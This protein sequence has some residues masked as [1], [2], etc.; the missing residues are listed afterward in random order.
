[1]EK[2][3]QAYILG[4]GHM[5]HLHQQHL[6]ALGISCTTYDGEEDCYRRIL[7]FFPEENEVIFVASPAQSHRSYAFLALAYGFD[8]FVE[9][10]IALSM[11]EVNDLLKIAKQSHALLFAG[12]CERYSLAFQNF[13]KK[14]QETAAKIAP[15]KIE[16]THWNKPT[17]RGQDVSVIWDLGVHDFDLLYTMKQA[18]PSWDSEK[19]EIYFDESREAEESKREIKATFQVD[20]VDFVLTCNLNETQPM[21]SDAIT[22]EIQE[23]LRIRA[24]PD[25]ERFEAMNSQLAGAIFAVQEA[26]KLNDSAGYNHYSSPN[27]PK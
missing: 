17:P 4:N 15:R 3:I 13:L 1:M 5:G 8:V 27:K 11:T 21:E 10:P 6:E 26:E 18:V 20:D 22:R 25:S 23:F 24:L 12:H 19:T 2:S 9:K 14:F 7:E 16:F